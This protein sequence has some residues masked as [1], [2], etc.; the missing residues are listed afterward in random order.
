[1]IHPRSTTAGTDRATVTATGFS[2]RRVL[3]AGAAVPVGAALLPLMPDAAEAAVRPLRLMLPSPGGPHRI[4]T[5][6]LHLVDWSRRDPYVPTQPFRELM[7]NLTYPARDTAGRPRAGW[8]TPA[9]AADT[10]AVL[11][12]WL[13]PGTGAGTVDWAATRAHAHVDAP[14]DGYARPVVIFTVGHFVGY[15]LYRSAIEDLASRGYVVVTF[16]PT[17]ETPVEFPNGRLVPPNHGNIP[18]D[19]YGL[20]IADARFILDQLALLNTGRNPDA[21]GR[22]LPP[23]LCG[24]VDV[25]R[26]GAISGGIGAGAISPQLAYADRRVIAAVIGDCFVG[27]QPVVVHGTDRPVLALVP[28]AEYVLRLGP[29]W[30]QMWHGLRGW[31]RELELRGGGP[32]SLSDAQSILP[33]LR[34]GLDL[35]AGTY[36]HLIGTVDPAP[37]VAAQRAYA[38]AF[39]DRHLRRR[40]TSLLDRPSPQHPVI[41]FVR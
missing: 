6:T 33:Q 8:L 31:R 17:Y 14:V 7:V 35:P 38:A 24:A 29:R 10:A 19:V 5:T 15:S 41:R 36:D 9:W 40:D 16:D 32:V 34:S 30:D 12:N 4:G 11:G 2:R 25:H 1:M 26:T 28:T 23:G 18:D 21:S 20:R 37:A 27:T 13:P 3:A 22:A 39:F